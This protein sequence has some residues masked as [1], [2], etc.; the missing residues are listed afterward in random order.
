MLT[1]AD[2]R[3]RGGWASVPADT[4]EYGYGSACDCLH[5]VDGGCCHDYCQHCGSLP[6][7]RGRN[8]A[9]AH[10]VH[11]RRRFVYV[12]VECWVLGVYVCRVCIYIYVSNTTVHRRRRYTPT[13][14]F[15]EREK[16]GGVGEKACNIWSQI[17]PVSCI[18]ERGEEGE[19]G[20]G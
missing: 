10:L 11:V 15:M 3:I 14:I 19:R 1:F 9:S 17:P 2:V 6:S 4:G 5:A 20:P 16:G 18:I 12:C 7:H 8:R 13:N